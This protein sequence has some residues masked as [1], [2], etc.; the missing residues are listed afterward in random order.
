MEIQVNHVIGRIYGQIRDRLASREPSTPLVDAWRIPYLGRLLEER[1]Q[2]AY[3]GD[4]LCEEFDDV[5]DLIDSLCT[6]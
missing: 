4:E 6:N 3:Q 1:D 5:Q 2:L